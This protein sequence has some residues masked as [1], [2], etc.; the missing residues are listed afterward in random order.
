MKA[1]SLW[2]P[3]A[4][5]VLS[6]AKTLETRGWKTTHRG[7][8]LITS[9]KKPWPAPYPSTV[10]ICSEKG[11]DVISLA[12]ESPRGVAI[13][14]VDVVDSRSMVKEDDVNA[15]IAFSFNR[16]VFELQ[17]I[18]PVKQIPISGKQGIF[19]VE[20]DLIEYL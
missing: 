16:F 20:D 18:R 8:L 10:K 9:T 2:Q 19:N 5:L 12:Q 7:P 6:G 11:I 15:C 3:F 1:L 17:N 4:A 13:C 14:V